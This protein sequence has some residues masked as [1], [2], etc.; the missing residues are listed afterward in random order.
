MNS[1][2]SL[3][4]AII[5][6]TFLTSALLAEPLAIPGITFD[7]GEVYQI[8]PGETIFVD[9]PFRWHQPPQ[10]VASQLALRTVLELDEPV[11]VHVETAGILY[12]A[13]WQWDFG[14]LQHAR[15]DAAEN[16]HGW[17]HLGP[18]GGSP[19]HRSGIKTINWFLKTRLNPLPHAA[20]APFAPLHLYSRALTP[21][22]AK[23]PLTAYHGQWIIVGFQSEPDIRIASPIT[24]QVTLSATKALHN[25]CNPHE[26]ITAT[27]NKPII[28]LKLYHQGR[29][30][31]QS[32][33]P[34]FTAPDIPGRYCLQI[35]FQKPDPDDE[36]S[37]NPYAPSLLPLTVAYE[38]VTRQGWPTDYFPI[39]FWSGWDYTGLFIPNPQR[40]EN[41]VTI[42][43]FELGA[44]TSY[45]PPKGDPLLD[46]LN[47]RLIVGVR[48]KTKHQIRDVADDEF[49]PGS[50]LW[51]IEHLGPFAPNVLGFHVEDEPPFRA[52]QRLKRCLQVFREYDADRHL[53]YCLHGP[54][55]PEFWQI[56][57]ATVRQT[58]AY[59]IRRDFKDDFLPQIKS[60]LADYL[61][62]CQSADN[63][64][65]LWF[66]AQSFGDLGR[67]D[68]IN[69]WDQPTPEQ[70]RL[71]INLALA[72]GIKGLSY[73]CL[74]TSPGGR[75]DLTAILRH[76]YVPHDTLYHEVARLNTLIAK[77]GPFLNTLYWQKT[78]EQPDEQL[79]IQLLTNAQ[80]QSF[81][82]VTNFNYNN[83]AQ[84]TLSLQQFD[85]PQS[86]SLTPGQGTIINLATQEQ[87]PF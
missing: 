67:P 34:T 10:A 71:M 25:V 53:F 51:E 21:G 80:N 15:G 24:P 23:L 45:C 28:S 50:F 60:E 1:T 65:P 6:A 7:K 72:R 41:L 87:V 39:L 43:Q 29:V 48:G 58:R 40:L 27:S 36:Y 69:R 54:R 85:V 66:V 70:L 44:N 74:G 31:L 13:F 47:M 49:R 56:A 62:A 18:L 3:S 38:P 4:P 61:V 42:N 16:I 32:Q 17:H 35:E 64:T 73:F 63:S 11:T 83:P 59:P 86:I 9:Q 77:H 46:A 5:V 57:G 12:A 37:P 78:L 22:T 82:Y 30:V 52:A 33:L 68:G 2:R 55:A 75:E 8:V 79:D 26:V 84:A 19:R 14:F 81:A 20:P 76:P